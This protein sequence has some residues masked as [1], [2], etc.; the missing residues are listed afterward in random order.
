MP[1]S[2][3]GIFYVTGLGITI[4]RSLRRTLLRSGILFNKKIKFILQLEKM[5]DVKSN[6]S[7]SPL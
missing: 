5:S 1:V 2:T 3:T 6:R 7:K 4:G